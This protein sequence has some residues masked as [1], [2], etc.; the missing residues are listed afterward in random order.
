MSFKVL[1]TIFV[2]FILIA[3][4]IFLTY[5]HVSNKFQVGFNSISLNSDPVPNFSNDE[6]DVLS[7]SNAEL[8]VEF[9]KFRDVVISKKGVYGVYVKSFP[10]LRFD[11]KWVMSGVT[12][13]SSEFSYN[14]EKFFYGASLF[15]TPV[16]ISLMKSVEEKKFSL[17]SKVRYTP[18][19][20]AD[21]TGDINTYDYGTEYSLDEVLVKLL[22]KS[23]NSAQNILIRI[24]GINYIGET[25]KAIGSSTRFYN[26]NY[27]T[28]K[29]G[30]LVFESLI[31]SSLVDAESSSYILKLLDKTDF[32]DRIEA[33]LGPDVRFSH[34]IGTDGSSWHDCGLATGASGTVVVCLLSS[35]TN[36][37][38]F[39]VVSKALGEFVGVLV[40]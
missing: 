6:D 10:N 32:D 36:L 5:R 26:K 14:A 37:G 8:D 11:D 9:K 25:F 7:I 22:Q 17:E 38:D 2:L 4:G 20:F 39:K 24:L 23:D 34:K 31:N 19:D 40:R 13:D 21:G 29:D 1:T 18:A 15:K 3:A 16:A 28:P 35:E 33:G 30:V 27:L 12:R